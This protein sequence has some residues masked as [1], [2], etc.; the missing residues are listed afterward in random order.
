[1]MVLS[2][3]SNKFSILALQRADQ[4]DGVPQHK[5][6]CLSLMQPEPSIL[7]TAWSSYPWSQIASMIT[8]TWVEYGGSWSTSGPGNKRLG[9]S[10]SWEGRWTRWRRSSSHRASYYQEWPK[11]GDI[12]TQLQTWRGSSYCLIFSTDDIWPDPQLWATFDRVGLEE[13]I[14]SNRWKISERLFYQV[15]LRIQIS[16]DPRLTFTVLMNIQTKQEAIL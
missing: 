14:F 6:K 5:D 11:S 13:D 4:H 16:I 10:S 15:R 2:C 12:L 8:R 9:W 1:M 7:L 3:L